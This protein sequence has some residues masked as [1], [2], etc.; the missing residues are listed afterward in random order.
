MTTDRHTPNDR[1]GA[2]HTAASAC[3]RA[4]A[5]QVR[6]LLEQ[7]LQAR[8]QAN[9]MGWSRQDVAATRRAM[10]LVCT[11]LE[12]NPCPGPGALRA[13]LSNHWAAVRTMMP[14]N[15]AG[16]KRLETIRSL[17]NSIHA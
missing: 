2:N 15:A 17:I 13:L 6:R 10:D 4:V 7:G 16:K 9:A 12:R 1:T 11:W 5:Q 3:V 14:Y 8:A